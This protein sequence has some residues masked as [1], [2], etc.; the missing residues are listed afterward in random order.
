MIGAMV[1]RHSEEQALKCGK[2]STLI[3]TNVGANRAYYWDYLKGQLTE[4]TENVPTHDTGTS[5]IRNSLD[6][7]LFL[8]FFGFV[9]GFFWT[10]FV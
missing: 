2:R 10:F 6:F 7:G 5:K 4:L 3:V 1:I 9:F 8:G